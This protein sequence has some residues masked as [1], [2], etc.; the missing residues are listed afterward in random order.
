MESPIKGFGVLGDTIRYVNGVIREYAGLW[1]GS[2]G[3]ESI[4]P[5]NLSPGSFEAE[6]RAAIIAAGGIETYLKIRRGLADL[7][8]SFAENE[9][10]RFEA[11]GGPIRQAEADLEAF[12]AATRESVAELRAE[13]SDPFAVLAASFQAGAD[14]FEAIVDEETGNITG[15]IDE[16]ITA[17]SESATTRATFDADLVTLAV[18]GFDDLAAVIRERGPEASGLLSEFLTDPT[19]AA[20]AER[21]LEGQSNSLAAS[22]YETFKQAMTGGPANQA[23]IDSLLAIANAAESPSVRNAL[24]AAIEE[25]EL[26][27]EGAFQPTFDLDATFQVNETR[28]QQGLAPNTGGG[29]STATASGAQFQ[30]ASQVININNATT[31]DVETSAAQAAQT[32][33]AISGLVN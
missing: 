32:L 27:A 7:D 33:G 18:A 12:I 10:R 14:A 11:L 3:V 29:G 4:G 8:G 28:R 5:P 25:L 22:Y 26:I 6:G 21:V 15:S 9:A 16:F 30:T 1:F 24:L 19:A 13:D 20:E 31:E 23:Y 2:D 17:L